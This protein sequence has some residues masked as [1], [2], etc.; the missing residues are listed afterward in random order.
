MGTSNGTIKLE[1]ISQDKIESFFNWL[2]GKSFPNDMHFEHK[3]N[4][5][6]AEAFSVI[7]YLQE[8]LVVLP[9]KYEMCGECKV[10]FDSEN[11]G[12][13]IE[14]DSTIIKDGEE[15]SGNFAE[16]MYGLYCD[17]CRPD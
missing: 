11:E 6:A 3:L 2:Q 1:Q 16:E 17:S 15:I 8:E 13:N 9:D 10:I 4:L 7:Y 5:S 14:K 12:T